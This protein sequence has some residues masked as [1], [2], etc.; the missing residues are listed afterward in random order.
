VI[1]PSLWWD[2]G[3]LCRQA[4]TAL[5]GNNDLRGTF[6]LSL[7]NHPLQ[8]G[9]TV[10]IFDR[11]IREF[12]ALLQPHQT[13]SFRSTMQYFEAEDHGSE[14]LPSLY[15]GLRFI[16]DGFKP[17]VAA[18]E[19]AA[20]VREH[21]AKVSARLGFTIL[22][23]ETYVNDWGWYYLSDERQ[24][25]TALE[26]LNLNMVNYPLSPKAPE[27][28][29]EAYQFIGNKTLAAE[30]FQLALKAN[31]INRDAAERLR[32]LKPPSEKAG[33]PLGDGVYCMINKANGKSLEAVTN[34]APGP[35]LRLATYA[36]EPC[37]QWRFLL[38]GDGYYQVTAF[39][40]GKAL[41]VSALSL[42]NGASVLLWNTNGGANQSWQLVPNPDGTYRLLN[43][44]S[45]LALQFAKSVETNSATLQQSQWHGLDSQKW[46]L[47]KVAVAGER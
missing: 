46:R 14:P 17:S 27:N 44:H 11:A 30:N 19:T 45:G 34:S 26:F 43:E 23:P 8:K 22:P 10:K 41:D 32:R 15:Y 25:N 21:F 1:D 24:T 7:A 42:Q 4:K 36:R 5:E 39:Q 47:K 28:L 18:L 31:P 37:Q 9:A 33:G 38:E 16:F 35:S 20:G 40:D 12:A 2:E 3:S 6:Y 13:E 29:A